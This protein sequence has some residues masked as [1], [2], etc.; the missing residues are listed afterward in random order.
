VHC[1]SLGGLHDYFNKSHP[2]RIRFFAIDELTK[3]KS[4]R[5]KSA[6]FLIELQRRL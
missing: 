5:W 3:K 2:E 4:L 6:G 1:G